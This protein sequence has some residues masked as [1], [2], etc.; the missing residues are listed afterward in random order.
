M[1][2]RHFPNEVPALATMDNQPPTTTSPLSDNQSHNSRKRKHAETSV[3]SKDSS[4][5][6]SNSSGGVNDENCHPSNENPSKKKR[7]R[8][9]ATTHPVKQVRF[10]TDATVYYRSTH[11]QADLKQAKEDLWWSKE[12]QQRNVQESL[13]AIRKFR[14]RHPD[15]ATQFSTVYRTSMEAPSQASSDYLEQVTVSLPIQMRGLEWGISPKLKARRRQHIREVLIAC[16]IHDD[17]LRERF[18]SSRSLRS[19]RPA[20]IMAKL[21]G[22]GNAAT[23]DAAARKKKKTKPLRR[24]YL[25]RR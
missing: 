20:R 21:L 5:C 9:T 7:T 25:W 10:A 13:V 15:V 18:V 4:T 8:T 1:G 22:E 3:S 23:M 17:A 14:K 2:F 24:R 19:S 11:T 16:D 12:K 6:S